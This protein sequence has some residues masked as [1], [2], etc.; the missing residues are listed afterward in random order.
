MTAALVAF[1]ITAALLVIL[2]GP[3][4]LVVVRN[5]LRG[6]RRGGTASAFGVMTGLV[7]WVGGA[8]AGISAMLRAS[9][10][11][12]DGLRIAGA[13]YLVWVGVQSLRARS[14]ADD[15]EPA[16]RPLLG[17]GYAAGLATDLLNPKVGVMFVSMLPSFVPRGADVALTSLVFGAIFIVETAVYFTVLVLLAG[18]VVAWMTDD[19]IRRRLER[20]AGIVFIG[21]GVRLVTGD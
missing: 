8:V 13:C 1:T 15:V 11:G 16:K 9:R 19:R 20:A 17:T 18:R 4:T 21:F 5:L 12:Y 7:V 14:A 2:P 6:G 10:I 3:D